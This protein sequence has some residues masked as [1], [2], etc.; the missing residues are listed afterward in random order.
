MKQ[1]IKVH[2][3]STIYSFP[4]NA[5][6]LG[7]REKLF[8]GLERFANTGDT[9]EDYQGL[10]KGWPAFWPIRIYDGPKP[11]AWAPECHSLFLFY[12]DALRDVWALGPRAHPRFLSFLLGLLWG[13]TFSTQPPAVNNRLHEIWGELQKLHPTLDLVESFPLHPIWPRG[14]FTFT[15]PTTTPM[16]EF[17]VAL[18]DLFRESWRAKVCPLCGLYFIAGKAPQRYCSAVCS[19]D[20]HRAQVLSW[21]RREGSKQRAEKAISQRRKL[22]E[23][24]IVR[25]RN[26][27]SSR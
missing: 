7:L 27:R 16:N 21:W 5:L 19:N 25:N 12:R 20:A 13:D 6:A 26:K 9:F 15:A 23:K 17:R 18:W 4:V 8:K 14:T 3:P 22:G 11:L 10:G 2:R 1:A 24:L